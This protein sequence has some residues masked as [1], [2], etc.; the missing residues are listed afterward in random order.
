MERVVAKRIIL[1]QGTSGRPKIINS[2]VQFVQYNQ[3]SKIKI[4]PSHRIEKVI[5]GFRCGCIKIVMHFPIICLVKKNSM[6]FLYKLVALHA[7][8]RTTKKYIK[9]NRQKKKKSIYLP[10]P[11]YSSELIYTYIYIMECRHHST[12]INPK[13][14]VFFGLIL[15]AF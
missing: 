1:Q 12:F 13:L 5:N 15:F 2:F 3:F 6:N 11:V 10:L 8:Q 7:N 4:C 9:A 14:T